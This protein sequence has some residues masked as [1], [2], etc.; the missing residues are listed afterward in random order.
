MRREPY[1]LDDLL[2]E[3]DEAALAKARQ[4]IAT[5]RQAWADMTPEQRAAQT[6]AY[7]A[8]YGNIREEEE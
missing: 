1:T 2:R 5:E 6:E 8:K 7:E 4:E 3:D